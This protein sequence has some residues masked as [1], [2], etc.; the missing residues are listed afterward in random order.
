MLPPYPPHLKNFT[1]L[2]CKMH[3]YFIWLKVCCIPPNVGG[4]EK[5]RLWLGIG[6][7][8]KNRLWCAANGM[9]GKQCY[10]KCSKWPPSAQ[11]HASSL[12]RPWSTASSTMLCWNSA[13]VATRR[14]C[15]SSYRRLVLNTLLKN[16]QHE[17]LWIL[18]VSAVTFFRWGG[19]G[20]T[21]CFL[22]R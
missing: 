1:A 13:H 18:Q 9:S 5:S 3:N 16:E 19:K 22:L 10:S 15:N 21:V 14:F 20:I 2:P 12:F 4:S 6:G 8:E 7:S 17:K 11:I